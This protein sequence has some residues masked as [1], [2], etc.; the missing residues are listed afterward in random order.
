MT[1]NTVGLRTR[2]EGVLKE[3]EEQKRAEGD[4]NKVAQISE[5]RRKFEEAKKNIPGQQKVE[6][7]SLSVL[8]R[9]F[10]EAA[11]K[12]EN[13]HSQPESEPAHQDAEEE[14]MPPS[15]ASSSDGNLED[16]CVDKI[17]GE[18]DQILGEVSKWNPRH[19]VLKWV[20]VRTAAF[21]CES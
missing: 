18:S 16:L 20:L 19:P 14:K 7:A 15:S 10:E 21:C 12:S 9:K 17:E 4:L 8:R 5:L 6:V 11:R 2:L 13:L 1:A 3:R